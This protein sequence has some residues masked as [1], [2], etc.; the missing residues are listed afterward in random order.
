L[1]ARRLPYEE[2]ALSDSTKAVRIATFQYQAGRRDFLW[3]SN[4]QAEQL[5]IQAGVIKARGQQRTNRINLYLALGG[6][7]SEKPAAGGTPPT[8]QASG[9]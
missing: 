3:V 1:I 8:A 9:E 2:A 7:I 6:G 5:A 4:L